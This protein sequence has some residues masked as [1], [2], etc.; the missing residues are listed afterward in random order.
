MHLYKYTDSYDLYARSHRAR[1]AIE[2]FPSGGCDVG[3]PDPPDPGIQC[4]VGG[5]LAALN[6]VLFI[7]PGLVGGIS[8]EVG[9][10]Q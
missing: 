1:G 2:K 5:D 10:R 7:F 6:L 3:P 4:T 9:I 8:P